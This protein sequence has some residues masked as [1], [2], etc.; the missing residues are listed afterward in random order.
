M[1]KMRCSV[2]PHQPSDPYRFNLCVEDHENTNY[3]CRDEWVGEDGITRGWYT[4]LMPD[5]YLYNYT[6]IAHPVKGYQ[7]SVTRRDS[8]IAMKEVE[9]DIFAPATVFSNKGITRFSDFAVSGV[10]NRFVESQAMNFDENSASVFANSFT[11]AMKVQRSASSGSVPVVSSGPASHVHGFGFIRDSGSSGSSSVSASGSG[12]SISS[13]GATQQKLS[14]TSGSA[15]S[16]FSSKS[17]EASGGASLSRTVS[18]KTPE[19]TSSVISHFTPK[20]HRFDATGSVTITKDSSATVAEPVQTK[21]VAQEIVPVASVTP[22]RLSGASQASLSRTL[23]VKTPERVSNVISHFTP[24]DHRFDATG[25]VTINQGSSASPARQSKTSANIP[26]ISASAP[27][28]V[29]PILTQAPVPIAR[30]LSSSSKSSLSRTVSVKTPE[31]QSSVISHFTPAGHRYEATGS[32]T[33]NQGNSAPAVQL[34]QAPVKIQRASVPSPAP[35]P[36]PVR[37][38]PTQAPTF[39]PVGRAISS[40]SQSSLSRTVSVKTPERQS[41]VISHFTPADHRYDAT[42][43]VVINSG[44]SSARALVSP[45]PSRSPL[46]APA[47]AQRAPLAETLS[48]NAKSISSANKVQA[49]LSRTVSVKTPERVSGVISHF[50]PADHRYEATGSVVINSGSSDVSAQPSGHLLSRPQPSIV[51]SPDIVQVPAKPSAAQASLSRTVSV[52]TPERVSNVISHFNPADHRFDATGSVVINQESVSPSRAA[53]PTAAPV[54]PPAAAL[55]TDLTSGRGR[56][57]T[58]SPLQAKPPT[59]SRSPSQISLTRTVSVKSPERVSNVIAHFTPA[60]HKYDATGS[61]TI[62]RSSA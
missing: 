7:V 14:L 12:K 13:S 50:T 61:V 25:S 58:D 36:A 43:S 57:L 21:F 22:V 51:R 54:S 46:N 24:A 1:D 56:S 19:R 27:A 42:G 38:S 40:S 39:V 48:S 3:Q 35:A 33:I 62:N 28:P 30:A 11:E 41:S 15:T 4:V 5:A 45:K 17:S 32:V 34:T 37:P 10:N 26:R 20:D 23:S 29:R 55:A 16:K 53:A 8:G 6:Y 2:Y 60:V 49:S 9:A 44:T 47:P 18:I 59:A 52:K 31:R